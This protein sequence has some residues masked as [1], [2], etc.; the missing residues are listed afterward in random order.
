M[1]N[2]EVSS[3]NTPNESRV[4]RF[5]FTGLFTF[6]TRWT[7]NKMSQDVP[8]RNCNVCSQATLTEVLS[9]LGEPATN[10]L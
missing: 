3:H 8:E 10:H 9:G 6:F 1:F 7:C 2:S 5:V 4:L